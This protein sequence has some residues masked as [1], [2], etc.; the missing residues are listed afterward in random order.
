MESSPPASQF[1]LLRKPRFWPLF[2]TQALGAFNDNL[3]KTT[4]V[5]ALA[6]GVW[7]TGDWSPEM[8]VTLAAGLFIIPFVLCAPIGGDLADKYDKATVIQSVK[9]VEIYLVIAAMFALWF[10]NIL[11]L[12]AV[13]LAFGVQ[14]A[15]FSP[16]KFSI[17]PQHLKSQELIGGNALLNTGS[18]L[19][20]LAGTILGGLWGAESDNFSFVAGI[21]ILCAALGYISSLYIPEAPSSVPHIKIKWNVLA[22]SHR[23]LGYAAQQGRGVFPAILGISWFYFVGGTYLAQFPNFTARILYTDNIVLTL[24]MTVFSV[25]IALG[26]LINNRLLDSRIDLKYVPWAAFAI[27]LFSLDLYA[28]SL[29]WPDRIGN[30]VIIWTAFL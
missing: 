21:L 3:Y 1:S 15:C 13:L 8:L 12:L 4:L 27:A 9:R 17:L 11:F 2:V 5:V 20:I 28:V 19:A 18:F 30:D 24:L 6:Y 16:S 25:G 10:G 14:S 23:I 26:G 7:P 22:E 29:Y